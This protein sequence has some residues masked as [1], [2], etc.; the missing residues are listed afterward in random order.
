[1]QKGLAFFVILAA[2]GIYVRVRSSM[3]KEDVGYE[4]V[5]S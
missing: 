1:M 4:K 3:R 5:I 2:I